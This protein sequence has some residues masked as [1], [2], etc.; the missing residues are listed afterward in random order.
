MLTVLTL[1]PLPV[2]VIYVLAQR[3]IIKSITAGA[4]KN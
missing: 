1:T 4:V 3:Q 2:L